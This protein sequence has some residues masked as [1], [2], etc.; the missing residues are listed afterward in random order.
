MQR[1]MAVGGNCDV[2]TRLYTFEEHHFQALATPARAPQTNSPI[3]IAVASHDEIPN[4]KDKLSSP[5][6]FRQLPFVLNEVVA[7]Q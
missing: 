4:P 6:A 5:E 7:G 2:P 1:D 3:F